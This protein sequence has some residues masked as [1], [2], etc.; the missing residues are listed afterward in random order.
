[1][2]QPHRRPSSPASRRHR[3]GQCP[4]LLRRAWRAIRTR[5][6]GMTNRYLH[7]QPR[8]EKRERA[9][10]R[11]PSLP[12][13]FQISPFH[14]RAIFHSERTIKLPKVA[15]LIRSPHLAHPTRLFFSHL[16]PLTSHLRPPLSSS[17]AHSSLPSRTLN[18]VTKPSLDPPHR[19]VH[20]RSIAQSRLF[21]LMS[22]WR[23]ALTV[24]PS[25]RPGLTG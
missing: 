17:T 1:M 9:P 3:F 21:N 11:L 18:I 6:C 24:S 5:R 10:T 23:M 7:R 12:A 8:Q 4:R 15:N 16:P 19:T 20:L 13:M 22:L 14:R 2:G 25:R